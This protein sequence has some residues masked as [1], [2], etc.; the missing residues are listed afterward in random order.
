MWKEN[1]LDMCRQA[2]A[3]LFVALSQVSHN[4][5]KVGKFFV[6]SHFLTFFLR[7]EQL[8]L[9]LCRVWAAGGRRREGQEGGGVWMRALPSMARAGITCLARAGSRPGSHH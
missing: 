9:C 3:E 2:V 5:Q 8:S 7:G 6:F 4:L 1:H